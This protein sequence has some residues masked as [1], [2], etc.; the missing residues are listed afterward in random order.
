[1]KL[2]GASNTYIRL[3]FLAEGV[4]AGLL[5]TVIAFG[6]LRAGMF[7]LDRVRKQVSIFQI[8]PAVGMREFYASCAVLLALGVVASALASLLALRKYVRI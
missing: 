2:V 5:G 4:V 8:L 1:M 3:P 6:L 7:Y